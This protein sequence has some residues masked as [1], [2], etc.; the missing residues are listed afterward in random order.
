MPLRKILQWLLLHLDWTF[1]SLAELTIF[2]NLTPSWFSFHHFP[3]TLCFPINLNSAYFPELAALFHISRPWRMVPLFSPLCGM[4][5]NSF[6]FLTTLASIYPL[7]LVKIPPSI[8]ICFWDKCCP[9]SCI[10]VYHI[11]R[12]DVTGSYL[13]D[14]MLVELEGRFKILGLIFWLHHLACGILVPRP[15]ME[16]TPAA[17]E[18]Q[19]P[20]HWIAR[21]FPKFCV[22]LICNHLATKKCLNKTKQEMFKERNWKVNKE[23]SK[24]VR[25][26]QVHAL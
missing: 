24:G 25:T 6:F 10:Y 20:N 9:I 5:L 3:F 12:H 17:G 19:S 13:P 15:G 18:A 11:L 16:A 2:H 7:L 22:L 21:E 14:L 8:D 1:V 23:G 4:L 26:T